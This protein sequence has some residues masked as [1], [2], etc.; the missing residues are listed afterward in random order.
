MGIDTTGQRDTS[1]QFLNGE[2]STKAFQ[3]CYWLADRNHRHSLN[4]IYSHDRYRM[5]HFIH[6]ND[7]FI[8]RMVPLFY[9]QRL[10]VPFPSMRPHLP[11]AFSSGRPGRDA[12]Y[13]FIPPPPPRAYLARRLIATAP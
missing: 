3:Y 1:D 10:R 7:T 8:G 13:S 9:S 12:H 2:K 5:Y 4:Y 6:M 11:P